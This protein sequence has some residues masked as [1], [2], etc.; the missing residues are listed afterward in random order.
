MAFTANL[1]TLIW[2]WWCVKHTRFSLNSSRLVRR[3]FTLFG[4][5]KKQGVIQLSVLL[6]QDIY[7]FLICIHADR[8]SC[9]TTAQ[10]MCVFTH[11][12]GCMRALWHVCVMLC[13]RWLGRRGN[14]GEGG[15]HLLLNRN[16]LHGHLLGLQH[17]TI[18]LYC[19]VLYSLPFNIH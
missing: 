9:I 11:R 12:A 4:L 10:C 13:G 16:G 8:C 6:F 7:I 19:N 17:T 15:Q 2:P 3:L 1:P 18:Y 5:Q 14:R